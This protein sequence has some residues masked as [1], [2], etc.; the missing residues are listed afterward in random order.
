MSDV[1]AD[2]VADVFATLG[3]AAV[4]TPAA[5]SEVSLYVNVETEHFSDPGGYQAQVAGTVTEIEYIISDIGRVAVIGETFTIGSTVYTIQQE[6]ENDGLTAK[7][8]VL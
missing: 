6:I 4:F 1:F 8:I 3:T 2:M 5:G 7:V